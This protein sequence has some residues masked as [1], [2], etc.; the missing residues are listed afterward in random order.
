MQCFYATGIARGH[1]RG[2]V[3][4]DFH[5]NN[6]LISNYEYSNGEGHVTNSIEPVDDVMIVATV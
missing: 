3:K 1:L 2:A 6:G 4:I 5:L